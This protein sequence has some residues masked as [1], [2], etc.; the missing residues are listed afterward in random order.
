M[1]ASPRI[2]TVPLFTGPGQLSIEWIKFFKLI[3]GPDGVDFS[4]PV[5]TLTTVNGKVTAAS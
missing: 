4:G 1:A 5:T 2:P 3:I